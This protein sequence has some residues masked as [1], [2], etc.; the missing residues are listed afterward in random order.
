MRLWTRRHHP[1]PPVA[2]KINQMLTE[3]KKC[4]VCGNEKW[5][6]QDRISS[7]PQFGGVENEGARQ[8]YSAVILTCAT[9]G[10]SLMFNANTL[11]FAFGGKKETRDEL[12]Q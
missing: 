1:H 8:H 5:N 7:A 3:S 6:L 11:G 10:N 4:Q 12:A 9:C 2:N